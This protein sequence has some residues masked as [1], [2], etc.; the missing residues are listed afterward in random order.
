M[1]VAHGNYFDNLIKRGASV[2]ANATVVCGVTLGE[3]CMVAAGAVVTRT[4]PAHALVMGNPG[5][6]RG[7][8]CKCGQKLGCREPDLDTIDG[9]NK[10]ELVCKQC[11][12]IVRVNLELYRLVFKDM[13]GLQIG[14]TM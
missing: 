6:L 5:R 3:Y 12:H 2:G 9:D 7:F 8:V 14:T 11:Q 13:E 1:S 10:V 4:V